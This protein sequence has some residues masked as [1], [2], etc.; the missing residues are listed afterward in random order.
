MSK[1]GRGGSVGNKFRMMLCLPVAVM[2]NCP[3]NIDA[4][5]LYI[6]SVNTIKGHLN[7]LLSSCVSNMVM[8]TV[9]KGKADLRQNVMQMS[10]S[11]NVSRGAKRMAS[12]CTL[13]IILV[14]L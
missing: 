14:S 7:K 9:N 1:R 3:D 5:N 6:I 2:V 13:K 10:L 4:K 11:D 12:S 8:T